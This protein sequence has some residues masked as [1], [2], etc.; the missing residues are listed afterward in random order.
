MD[1]AVLRL[2][3]CCYVLVPVYTCVH[4]AAWQ[5]G[6]GVLRCQKQQWT[7]VLIESVRPLTRAVARPVLKPAKASSYSSHAAF[8]GKIHH[9]P[10]PSLTPAPAS[11]AAVWCGSSMSA[12][13]LQKQLHRSTSTPHGGLKLLH[14]G[15]SSGRQGAAETLSTDSISQQRQQQQGMQ[16][17]R[18]ATRLQLPHQTH[19]PLRH[20]DSR[21]TALTSAA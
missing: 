10:T 6:R 11:V 15:D 19:K 13:C 12:C 9:T 3:P 18:H 2:H 8:I 21:S 17:W 7:G 4:A 5:T 20:G 14:S 1:Q 16:M